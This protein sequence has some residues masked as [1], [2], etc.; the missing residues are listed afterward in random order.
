M[1]YYWQAK[2]LELLIRAYKNC[3]IPRRVLRMLLTERL[4]FAEIVRH[5]K[6]ARLKPDLKTSNGLEQN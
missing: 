3:V 6:V 5:E 2:I 1:G 4:K